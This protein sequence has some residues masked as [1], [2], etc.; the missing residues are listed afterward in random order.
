MRLE[1]GRY[2]YLY[3][4]D[5]AVSEILEGG[6]NKRGTLS[7]TTPTFM[8]VAPSVSWTSTES[9]L[10]RDRLARRV[11]KTLKR[12]ILKDP[13]LLRQAPHISGFG[14]IEFGEF[15]SP[16]GEPVG[17]LMFTRLRASDGTRTVVC[18]FGSLD[19]FAGYLTES[20]TAS[21]E[22]WT[23][24]SAPYVREF[25]EGKCEHGVRMFGGNLESR[26]MLA[27]YVLQIASAQGIER[28]P[29]APW[30]RAFTYGDVQKSGEW[31]AEIY[32]DLSE[33]QVP[34]NDAE[35]K[36]WL[37]GRGSLDRV[38]IARPVWLRIKKQK[39]IRVYSRFSQEERDQWPLPT[40]Y[41]SYNPTR[42]RL[43]FR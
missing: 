30:N 29:F 21:R 41:R 31:L 23:S 1:R 35:A 39:D 27:H 38:I 36:R 37:F 3:W 4:S 7:L 12:G 11:E 9:T 2:K 24:S 6:A 40:G 28:R 43:L 25:L 8:N 16:R 14:Q 19:N 17:S 5:R 22:G 33:D 15:V 26:P 34:E 20:G 13:V 18:L 32:Y 10:Q 42:R